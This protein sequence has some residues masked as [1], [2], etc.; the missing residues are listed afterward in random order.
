MANISL[1]FHDCEDLETTL[2]CYH[3]V[4]GHIFIKIESNGLEFISLDKHTAIK[5]V[6]TLKTEISK[7]QDNG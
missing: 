1:R 6:K 7:M 2:E 5:L 3:N 4:K